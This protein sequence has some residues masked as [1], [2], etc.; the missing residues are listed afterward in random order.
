MFTT[1]FSA[2]VYGLQAYLV[3]VEVDLAGG[4]PSFQLVGSL[5]S[6]VK[7]SRERVSVAMKNSGFQI[8]P[9]HITVNLAPAGRR[10]DGTAFD[11]PVAVGL[12]RDMELVPEEALRYIVFGRTGPE[13]GD[14]EGEGCT[15]HCSGGGKKRYPKGGGARRKCHGG[16][17]DTGDH[18]LGCELSERSA[19]GTEPSGAGN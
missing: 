9:A 5:G 4:L 1:V 13:W 16:C 19:G 17:G 15:S 6:E 14:Q 18:G 7:E 10:K 12:L 3:R 11:L 2:A 8:P